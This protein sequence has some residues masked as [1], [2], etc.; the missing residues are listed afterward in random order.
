MTASPMYTCTTTQPDNIPEFG[1]YVDEYGGL[2]RETGTI[3]WEGAAERVAWNPPY[4]LLFNSNFIEIRH[5]ET[6]RLVQVIAG[7]GIRCVWDGRGAFAA[8]LPDED[9]GV[10]QESRVHG[11]MNADSTQPGRPEGEVMQHVFELRPMVPLCPPGSLSS[12]SHAS[13]FN[14]SSPPHSLRLNPPLSS[15]YTSSL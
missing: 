5:V 4:V 9:K 6:G 10:S 13:Y 14:H 1:L 8:N 15:S 11:V 3:E 2:S 12:P 7:N